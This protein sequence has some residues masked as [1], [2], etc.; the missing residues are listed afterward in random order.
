M[1]IACSMTTVAQPM[2]TPSTFMK[3]ARRSVVGSPLPEPAQKPGRPSEP[4]GIPLVA[5]HGVPS[6]ETLQREY[7]RT[8]AQR[9]REHL[10][11]STKHAIDYLLQG[12][13]SVVPTGATG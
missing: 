11:A 8:M 3:L 13:R 4:P 6:A 9:Q 10:P 2:P 5:V 12:R 1:I 7:E